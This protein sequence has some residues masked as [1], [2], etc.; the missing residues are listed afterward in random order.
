MTAQSINDIRQIIANL[1][2][3]PNTHKAVE[4]LE[5][6]CKAPRA[7]RAMLNMGLLTTNGVKIYQ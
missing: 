1:G 4:A 7:I 2:G 5:V 3:I 6:L